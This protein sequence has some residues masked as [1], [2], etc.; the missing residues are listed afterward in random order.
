MCLE[1]CTELEAAYMALQFGEECWC[2][3]DRALNYDRHG[4][5]DKDAVCQTACTGH[6]VL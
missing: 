4:D 6:K 2:S 3:A 1:H 5:H